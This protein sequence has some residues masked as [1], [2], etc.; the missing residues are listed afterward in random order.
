MAG[1][2]K[3]S[4]TRFYVFG[5]ALVLAVVVARILL[6]PREEIVSHKPAFIGISGEAVKTLTMNPRDNVVLTSEAGDKLELLQTRAEYFP[7]IARLGDNFVVPDDDHLLVLDKQLNLVRKLHVPGLGVGYLSDSRSSSNG[8]VAALYFN[9]GTVEQDER[10]LMV[11]AEGDRVFSMH[12]RYKPVAVATCDD[13]SVVWAEHFPESD[14]HAGGPG[15][16]RITRATINGEVAK[17]EF[18]YEAEYQPSF[19]SSINCLDEP[20]YVTYFSGDELLVVKIRFVDGKVEIVDRGTMPTPEQ[21]TI[22]RSSHGSG[23]KYYVYGESGAMHR[24]DLDTR[25]VDYSVKVLDSRFI[26]RSITFEGDTALIVAAFEDFDFEQTVSLV[27]LNNPQCVSHPTVLRG[28]DTPPKT[29]GVHLLP[30]DAIVFSILP[31]ER[32][33]KVNCA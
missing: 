32:N 20:S 21:T 11:L 2:V 25:S 29:F 14:D 28:Y 6:I 10:H 22:G 24:I 4:K 30:I 27:D 8:N 16:T 33:P 7:A 18:P 26:I 3:V 31:I 1:R 12:T 5:L 17:Y 9:D 23:N 15:I 13:A 19:D